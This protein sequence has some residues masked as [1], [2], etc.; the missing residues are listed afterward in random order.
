MLD[1]NIIREQ[2]DVVRK[3]LA[4]RQME[5]APVDQILELDLQRRLTLQEG[6]S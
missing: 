2:P 4:D 1:I 6:E 3:A 5:T